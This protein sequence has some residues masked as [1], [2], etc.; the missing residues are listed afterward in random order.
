MSAIDQ[1]AL[2]AAAQRR[3]VTRSCESSSQRETDCED[4]CASRPRQISKRAV[5]LGGNL[6]SAKWPLRGDEELLLGSH[7]V[8]PRR[9]YLHHG[10]YVGGGKIMHY[11]GLVH[12]LY[13]RPVEET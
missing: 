11:A 1:P 7:L 6:H 5:A 3:D 4:L 13:R 9:G 2:G 10:I 12:G 8:T